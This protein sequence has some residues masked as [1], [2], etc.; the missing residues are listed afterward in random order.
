MTLVGVTAGIKWDGVL[1]VQFTVPVAPQVFH[2][3]FYNCQNY[4]AA[5]AG[6]QEAGNQE[7]GELVDDTST[8]TLD[9]D[10]IVNVF[11]EVSL[12]PVCICIS[13]YNLL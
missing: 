1:Q 13:S 4:K 9:R 2:K 5:P 6:N 11:G 8:V 7:A 3:I 12:M 10:D